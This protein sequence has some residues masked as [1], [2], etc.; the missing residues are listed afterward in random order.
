MS[1]KVE[2]QTG[3]EFYE[4]SHPWGHG[5]PTI[6]GYTD[7]A[8][9]RPVCHAKHGVMAQ[10]IKTIMHTSTHVNA[11]IHLVQGGVGVGSIE[12]DRF[13]GNGVVVS[14]KKD[15]FELVSA[16]D[17]E[18]ASPEILSGDIVVLNT[19]WHHNYS[20]SQKY[21]GHGPGLDKG[22]AQWLVDKQVKL[23]GVD[24]AFVDQPLATSM[25]LHRNGPQIK[26]LPERYTKITGRDPREDFPEWNPAHRTLLGAGIPTIESVGGDLDEVTGKRCTFHAYPWNWSQG[27]ACVVRLMAIVDPSGEYRVE[28]GEA[29][30]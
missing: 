3:L 18:A 8:I 20:D 23:V 1:G 19:G 30:D 22:A 29:N 7:V 28:S 17:L 12:M 4:L 26:R 5:A 2:S 25:G 21:F 11:P 6:P 16:G 24:T 15:E 27:D 14:V 10:K 9:F 13:F